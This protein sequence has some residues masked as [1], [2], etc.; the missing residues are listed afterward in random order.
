MASAI[1]RPVDVHAYADRIVIKQA[2]LVVGEHSR[3]RNQIAYDLWHY[4]PVLARKPEAAR[5]PLQ[6]LAARFERLR[7]KLKVTDGGDPQMVKILTA[8]LT[9][10]LLAVQT[11][12]GGDRCRHRQ[13]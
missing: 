2:G 8:V 3:G 12:C 6:G 10:G 13:R 9:D 11:A 7:R 5:R 1:D 4:A